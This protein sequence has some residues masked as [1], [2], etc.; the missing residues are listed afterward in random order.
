[1]MRPKFILLILA[2]TLGFFLVLMVSPGFWHRK[3]VDRAVAVRFQNPSPENVAALRL[4]QGNTRRSQYIVC[5][6]AVVNV[7]VI[8][9][10]RASQQCKGTL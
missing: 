8:I 9:V 5:S 2:I 1:M 10:Y 7:L 3:V 6:L 4:E